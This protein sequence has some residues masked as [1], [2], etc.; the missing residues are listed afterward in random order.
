M[1]SHS[2]TELSQLHVG[3]TFVRDKWRM[4]ELNAGQGELKRP[5]RER[6]ERQFVNVRIGLHEKVRGGIRTHPL[7]QD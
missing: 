6:Q 3:A 2:L 7:W 5:G 4:A 1:N